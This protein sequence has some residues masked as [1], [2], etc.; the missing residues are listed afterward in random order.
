[1]RR[2]V[3]NAVAFLAAVALVIGCD[4]GKTT[5]PTKLDQPLPK[6][7]MSGGGG[8][9][10]AAKNKDGADPAKNKDGADPAK[11]KDGADPAKNKD[12]A[13]PAKNKDA[14][15]NTKLD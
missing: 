11:N 12:G 14:P 1:M 9:E 2:T 4:S 7:V 15:P 10:A 13:D 5:I 3:L 8:R 6:V